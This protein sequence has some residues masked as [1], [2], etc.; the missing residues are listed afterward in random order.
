M[1][2]LKDHIL[3]DTNAKH[4]LTYADNYAI[5][6]FKKQVS[7][8]MTIILISKR[9]S[10]VRLASQSQCGWDT[11]RIT[12]EGLLCRFDNFYSEL[13]CDQC[14]MVPGIRYLQI[15]DLLALQKKVDN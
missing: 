15:H 6:Y 9:D 3:K 13:M 10:H 7:F 14:S 2:H 5:G 1:N 11:S 12:K 8:C 4:F